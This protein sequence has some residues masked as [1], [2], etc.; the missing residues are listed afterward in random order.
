VNSREDDVISIIPA[1]SGSSR[2]PRKNISYLGSKRLIEWAISSAL[3]SKVISRVYVSTESEE[4]AEI[5]RKAGALPIMRPHE[6]ATSTAK[7]ELVIAHALGHIEATGQ[8]TKIAVMLQPTTP[9][10]KAETIRKAVLAVKGG[11]DTA[12]SIFLADKKPWWAFKMGQDGSL[13]PFMVLPKDSPYDS[14]VPPPLFYPTGGVYAFKTEF[15]HRTKM[16]Y[17][18]KAYGV[19]V[20]WY[21]AIDIDSEH[22]MDFAKFALERLN[23]DIG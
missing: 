21:E 7:P 15:F 16:V 14:E 3:S 8:V 9:L 4:Y 12:L 1:R 5:A 13:L 18:G 22:D 20:D 10:T 19:L 11:F 2:F 6:L 23:L 17:G